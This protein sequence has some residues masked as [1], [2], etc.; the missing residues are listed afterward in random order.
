MARRRDE[1]E[2]YEGDRPKLT[3]RDVMALIWAT[4]KVSAPYL[5]VFLLLFL[6]ALWLVTEVLFR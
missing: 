5:L 1:P 6:L 4:Y 3:T 2:A